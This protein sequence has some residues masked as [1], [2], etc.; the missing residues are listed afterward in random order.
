MTEVKQPVMPYAMTTPAGKAALAQRDATAW[1][2]HYDGLIEAR[3]QEL[4]ATDPVLLALKTL[5]RV[6]AALPPELLARGYTPLLAG[7]DEPVEW[8]P[9]QSEDIQ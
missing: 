4:M 9:P 7:P 6:A 3:L 5:Q 1:E 2:R 8:M